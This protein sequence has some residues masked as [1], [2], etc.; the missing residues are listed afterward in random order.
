MNKLLL[1]P[2]YIELL[3]DYL[4]KTTLE[5]Q[6]WMNTAYPKNEAFPEKL[7]HQTVHNLFVRSK[8][9]S[10]IAIAMI[11]LKK[12]KYILETELY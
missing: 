1:D 11:F 2:A 6:L 4:S 8:S 5:P 10:M 12:F 9:E 7:V 3:S